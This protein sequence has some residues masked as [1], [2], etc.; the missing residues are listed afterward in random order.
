MG[1]SFTEDESIPCGWYKAFGK[2]LLKDIKQAGKASRKR[3]HKH[4][5]WKQMI[6]WE[7]IKEK[8]GTL[9][10]YDLGAPEKVFEI[11][12]KYEQLSYETCIYCGKPSEYE[13]FG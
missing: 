6:T 1:Y 9:R 4:L 13:T 5:N 3:L 11:I 12:R 10:W 7:Q 2:D 8:Y